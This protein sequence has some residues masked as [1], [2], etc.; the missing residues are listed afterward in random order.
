M[1]Q[2]DQD[3]INQVINDMSQNSSNTVPRDDGEP[4]SVPDDEMCPICFGRCVNMV[5]LGCTHRLCGQCFSKLTDKC[6]VC[7]AGVTRFEYDGE[8]YQWKGLSGAIE[9]LG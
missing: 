9:E 4:S 6:A 2:Y 1:A 7:R 3:A 5:T 8:V